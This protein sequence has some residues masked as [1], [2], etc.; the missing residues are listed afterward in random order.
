MTSPSLAPS[1]R[2]NC[3]ARARRAHSEC[4]V[5]VNK[6][7]ATHPLRQAL[8]E[9]GACGCVFVVQ[10]QALRRRLRQRLRGRRGRRQSHA[11]TFVVGSGR[12]VGRRLRFRRRSGLSLRACR[13][14]VRLRGEKTARG[15]GSTCQQAGRGSL[16]R[17]NG[18]CRGRRPFLA[19]PGG[20]RGCTGL[21]AAKRG[22]SALCWRSVPRVNACPAPEAGRAAPP[23]A[24]RGPRAAARRALDPWLP[25]GGGPAR[26]WGRTRADG[27]AERYA[28]SLLK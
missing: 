16:R 17:R 4:G 5:L 24:R 9:L 11:I 12:V 23:A 27:G 6:Q 10:A 22:V 3:G 7:A 1:P 25:R 28:K 20:R 13:A 18:R 19:P 15:S 8:V 26:R 14:G 21:S 2:S